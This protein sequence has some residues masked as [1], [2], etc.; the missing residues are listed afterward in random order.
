MKKTVNFLIYILLFGFS[1][2]TMAQ[3][4]RWASG[5]ISFSSQYTAN[6][7]WLA[8]EILGEPN[9]F[10]KYGDIEGSF[11]QSEKNDGEH[12][13]AVSFD[14][15]IPIS[16]IAIYETFGP[17]TIDSIFVS[18]PNTGQWELVFSKVPEFFGDFSRIFAVNF[19]LTEFAVDSVK[20]SYNS[21]IFD[22][23]EEF[24]ALQVADYDLSSKEEIIFVADFNSESSANSW[25]FT[26]NEQTNIWTVNDNP[27][28]PENG[29]YSLF[30]SANN[31][32]YGYNNSSQSQSYVYH[33]ISFPENKDVF[34][35]EF[36]W[37]SRGE[38]TVGSDYDWM[39][40]YLADT[41]LTP[42]GGSDLGISELNSDYY[43]DNYIVRHAYLV[44]DNSYA[45]TIKRLI[46]G[47][48][49][50]D[51]VGEVPAWV[52]NIKIT[53]YNKTA[54]T[55]ILQVGLDY[56]QKTLEEA[57]GKVTANGIGTGGLTIQFQN[58]NGQETLVP[59]LFGSGI[60]NSEINIDHYIEGLSSENPLTIETKE[61]DD[62]IGFTNIGYQL[63]PEE[64]YNAR[65]SNHNYIVRLFDVAN[66][67]FKNIN[68]YAN[69]SFITEINFDSY[70]SRG[71]YL[72][73]TS[74]IKFDNCGFYG[75]TNSDPYYGGLAVLDTD[76]DGSFGIE[77]DGGEGT[78]A[79][80]ISTQEK[81]ASTNKKSSLNTLN[82]SFSIAKVDDSIV[83][84]S[85]IDFTNNDF[86]FGGSA[87]YAEVRSN[88]VI[89]EKSSP[90]S[91]KVAVNL[92]SPSAVSEFKFKDNSVINST[93]G[94][95]LV[96]AENVTI[97]KN[98]FQFGISTETAFSQSENNST[99]IKL[100]IIDGNLFVTKN[101]ISGSYNQALVVNTHN[102]YVVIGGE[103]FNLDG[104]I[105]NNI[106][107]RYDS[108]YNH[109]L[110]ISSSPN[111]FFM[112]NTIVDLNNGVDTTAYINSLYFLYAN[113]VI[114]DSSVLADVSNINVFEG[115]IV[116]RNNLYSANSTL[117]IAQGESFTSIDSLNTFLGDPFLPNL[118]LPFPL[119][120]NFR[121][122]GISEDFFTLPIPQLVPDDIDG[123]TRSTE[124]VYIGASDP[125]AASLPVELADFSYSIE[126]ETVVLNWQT[127]SETNN[128]GWEI[129]S[130]QRTT[131]NG[132][133][134]NTEFRK[135]GFV[136]GKGTTT[137]KQEYSFPVSSLQSSAS[138]VEFRLKQ[139]DLNGKFT[140]SKILTVEN[141]PAKFE[142]LGNYPNP[143]NPTTTLKFT[144][145][146]DSK[147]NITVFNILGQKV[148]SQEAEFKA[149]TI[150]L[151]F[152]ASRLS[153]GMYFYSIT[154]NQKSLVKSM[155]VIK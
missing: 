25:Q 67:T 48:R 123:F 148:F 147:I 13:I 96:H 104:S 120:E 98:N 99:G 126:N 133:Q 3:S 143:F 6:P 100:G 15:P 129:E 92:E 113:V 31:S 45:G 131:D 53:A 26:G 69:P 112:F 111:L 115:G 30:V 97:D 61:G 130:R 114:S 94:V 24:D 119:T 57:L 83:S 11:T 29:D 145:P 136:A 33:D 138:V 122:D 51:S 144:L 75:N 37:S 89:T 21:D 140:Y 105:T 63:N 91:N 109:M 82:R 124:I 84:N 14:N 149:G 150:L 151:P 77:E 64:Y 36:D 23:W 62:P 101:E 43:N 54:L 132:Q 127:K 117:L 118:S 95:N 39:D 47:W 108:Y 52:D 70:Y 16:S 152:D 139:I 1:F 56:P 86:M 8:T 12:F 35:L 17:G 20:F 87:V 38:H 116:M 107:S 2:T 90:V 50:D 78:A 49:N 72:S 135:V 128:S 102:S 146:S 60:Y 153:S 34:V 10:P 7:G 41:S 121:A 141:K 134:K 65:R 58:G 154:Y 85:N 40:V 44:L 73:N 71:V 68:F 5:V 88:P 76:Y 18:N 103:N 28:Y 155:M 22:S 93:F 110:S 9:V 42:N 19:P 137:E 80:G 142:L 106:F 4:S 81:A 66:I 46:F 74:N 125:I 27:F 55:G 79:P 59:S 32:T